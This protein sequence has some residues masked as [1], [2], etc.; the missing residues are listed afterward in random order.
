MLDRLAQNAPPLIIL[1]VGIPI[2]FF[3]AIYIVFKFISILIMGAESQREARAEAIA[4][5]KAAEWKPTGKTF[6]KP[7][8]SREWL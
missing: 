7:A 8:A 5:A 1:I 4:A 3:Y 6:K 2:L